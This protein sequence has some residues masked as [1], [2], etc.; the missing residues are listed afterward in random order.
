[1][2][3]NRTPWAPRRVCIVSETNPFEKHSG[4]A[5]YLDSVAAALQDGGA[6]LELIILRALGRHQLRR[7]NEIIPGYGARFAAIHTYD[8]TT[9]GGYIYATNPVHLFFRTLRLFNGWFDW[10]SEKFGWLAPAI[11]ASVAWA[12]RLLRKRQ[13]DMVLANYFNAAAVFDRAPE[14]VP[15]VILVHDVMALRQQSYLAAGLQF[16]MRASMVAEESAAFRTADLC[17]TIKEEEEAYIRSVAPQTRVATIPFAC[18][19]PVVDTGNP[20]S[21]TAVFVGSAAPPNIDGLGWLLSEVW[22]Q[23]RAARPDAR[24]RVVGK[25]ADAW[26]GPW[27]DG[28]EKVGFVD[29]LAAE[30]ARAALALTPL[31]YGSGV[32][33]KLIEGL[34]H[35]LPGVATTVGAEGV[36]KAPGAVLRVADGAR[37][38]AAAILAALNDPDPAATRRAALAFAGTHYSRDAVR[39]ALADALASVRPR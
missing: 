11:P 7:P 9:K 32:K 21:P 37:D 10:R 35:G 25:V 26:D 33:I 34:A 31:R 20:R 5:E 23:V 13:A 29:D 39:R 22:P 16:T 36:A 28:A 17:L 3:G 8:A 4:S 12:G 1:M 18:A 38:F 6:M 14:G 27:P 19:A 15:K 30:Y 2:H 24:L